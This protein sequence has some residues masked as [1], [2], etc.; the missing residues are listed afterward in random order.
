MIIQ[1]LTTPL[2][3]AP[4]LKGAASGV[5]TDLRFY[6]PFWATENDRLTI[7]VATGTPLNIAADWMYPIGSRGIF[8]LRLN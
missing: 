2:V 1:I 3:R 4:I 8:I 5:T 7:I 6:R